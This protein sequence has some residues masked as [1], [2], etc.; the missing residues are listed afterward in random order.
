MTSLPL[1]NILIPAVILLFPFALSRSQ[2]SLS[3]I[4]EDPVSG[5][6]YQAYDES[7]ALIVG[8]D[9]YTTVEPRSSSVSSATSVKELLMSRFGFR[10]EN[11]IFLSNEQAKRSTVLES[12]KKIQH[13]G[14]ED[15]LLLFLSGRG[16]T[17]VDSA[18]KEYG[19]FV[20]FDGRLDSAGSAAATCISLD[21][22]KKLISEASAKQ[23]LL[24]MDFTVGGLSAE[25]QFSGIPVPR[26]GFQRV[27]T[28]SCEE[29]FAAG[30]PN[31]SLTDD[32]VT[33][34]S[35]FTSKLIQALSSET[36]DVNSDGIITGTELAARTS[37]TV[38]EATQKKLHPQFGSIGAD[39]GDFLFILP[40]NTDTSRI[41][42]IVRP[43]D[44]A[45]FIDNKGVKIAEG[46]F[47]VVS[48]KIG[49]HTLQV[50]H[51]GYRPF[52][53]DFFVNGRVSIRANVDLEQ[54][55]P[56]GLM[57]RVSE[58]DARVSLDGNF[59]G[60]PDESLLIQHVEKGRHTVRADLEGYYSDSVSVTIEQPIQYVVS[61]NLVSRN[62]FL[63]VQSSEG[64]VIEVNEKEIG[65]Q[66]VVKK[67]VVPGAYE[68]R[69][70]GIGYT[71]YERT[72]VVHDGESVEINHPMSRPTLAGAL[73]RSVVFPGWGQSYSGRHGIVYSGI[74]VLC[75]AASIDLQL[76]YTQTVSDYTSSIRNYSL[77]QNH[78]DSAIFLQKLSS[79]RT[80][81][82]NF[83]YY[84]LAAFGVTG[85][86]YLYNII[87]VWGNDP[88]DLIREEEANSKRGVDVSLGIGNNGPALLLSF[89]F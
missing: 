41:S 75:A 62:G 7:Y 38:L 49:V 71:T 6:E 17:A 83:N 54:I 23:K 39:E 15:R 55:P 45:V 18:R 5:R 12:V 87:N 67:E 31:E 66:N 27:V 22:M 37:V 25:R 88:A 72:V 40:Q 30:G 34:L 32:P 56:T 13:L 10:E 63:T 48:P 51:E 35:C 26:L 44:A 84:R 70:S 4:V 78:A 24:L 86:F 9:A 29:I 76:A 47:P 16:Y 53:R 89:H 68:L 19:F 28:Q 85:A 69:L 52:K 20:P 74:F 11:I 8:I 80:R 57:V 58:P 43:P 33:G 81:K 42:F 59:V 60:M 46:S 1:R 73:V 50:Q 3:T 14:R 61:L 36:A 21:E 2:T 65:I 64:V 82:N 79:S 77:A